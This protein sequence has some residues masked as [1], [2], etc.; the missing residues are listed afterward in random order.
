MVV[1]VY[2]YRLKYPKT[3]VNEKREER[4]DIIVVAV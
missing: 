3:Y 2:L 1:Y 4:S